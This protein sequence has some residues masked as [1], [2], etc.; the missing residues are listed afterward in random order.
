MKA[1]LNR[2]DL[3][4]AGAAISA[5]PLMGLGLTQPLWARPPSFAS[6]LITQKIEEN[7]LPGAGVAFVENGELAWEG[8]YGVTNIATQTPVDEHTLFQAAS[9]SKPIFAYTVFQ[10]IDKGM[11]SLDDRLSD[12]FVPEDM[13]DHP[14]AKAVTVRDAL[15]HTA[16]LPNWRN[17]DDGP[18]PLMP[19]YEPGTDTGYSGEAYHWL[20]RVMEAVTGMGLDAL[21]RELLFRPAGLD[22]MAMLW[23]P[24]R[25]GREVYAHKF[26]E[27]GALIVDDFQYIREY[28]PRLHDVAVKWGKPMNTWTAS[29]HQRA[30]RE[31]EAP[32]HPR[33]IGLPSWRWSRPSL[34]TIDSASS[35]RTT[36]ANFARF[37]SLMMPGRPRA[38]WQITEA[39]RKL[40]LTPQYERPDVQNGVLPRGFGWGLEKGPNGIAFYHWGKNGPSHHAVAVGDPTTRRGIVVMTHGPNGKPFIREVVTRLM[41]QNYIGITT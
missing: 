31:M 13:A 34:T 12:H 37:L 38:E 16:G 6:D 15:Q 24:E 35:L 36:P 32:A 30:A 21:M 39:T 41:G 8:A 9:L 33:M 18:S 10:A 11:L 7:K 19:A 17:D 4:K 22:D 27:D 2:R 1:K 14:W 3:L 20:Q 40:M 26:D 5:L 25:D 28:G 23:S 29:D